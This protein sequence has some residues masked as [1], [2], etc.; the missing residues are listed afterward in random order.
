MFLPLFIFVAVFFID[1]GL[2]KNEDDRFS[3]KADSLCKI[4]ADEPLN[5]ESALRVF[6]DRLNS[7]IT[8]GSFGRVD[9]T[10]VKVVIPTMPDI[11]GATNNLFG[12]FYW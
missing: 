5:Q 8:N 2:V 11:P 10:S 9:V 3:T 1:T 4:L 12:F 7:M 6:R